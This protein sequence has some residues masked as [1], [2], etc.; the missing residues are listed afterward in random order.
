M[1]CTRSGC[2]THRVAEVGELVV[3][4]VASQVGWSQPEGIGSTRL[5]HPRMRGTPTGV[6]SR[7]A[8][9]SFQLGQAVKQKSVADRRCGDEAGVE[10]PV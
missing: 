5:L 6:H 4:W 9:F 10:G 1:N 3:G 2:Q 7:R 8:D